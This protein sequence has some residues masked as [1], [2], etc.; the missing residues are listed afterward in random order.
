MEYH[1]FCLHTIWDQAEVS[2]TLG[3]NAFY[4]TM[5]RNPVDQFISLWD[6]ASFSNILQMSLEDFARSD[7]SKL[8]NRLWWGILGRNQMMF[9]FG[10]EDDEMENK[11]I[12]DDKIMEMDKNFDLVLIHERFEE[13]M[14]LLKEQLCWDFSDIVSM[15]LNKRPNESKSKLSDEGRKSLEEYLDA[16]IRLYTH[17]KHKF[18]Q[19]IKS[20]DISSLS[21]EIS[22]L[23]SY[24]RQS[25]INCNITEENQILNGIPFKQR[26]VTNSKD[27]NCRLLVD[28]NLVGTVRDIQEER[29]YV[30][31]QRSRHE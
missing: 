6:D 19:K 10:L 7:K 21:N 25:K 1:L 13:S 29:V 16:D 18:E 27:Q 14:I 31:R 22:T 24:T 20:F 23:Q 8:V 4:F 17:F 30:M 5:L 11:T 12:I 9:D 15:K 3:E 26:L 2:A 28:L